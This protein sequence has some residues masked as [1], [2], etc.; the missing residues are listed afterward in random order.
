MKFG[1]LLKNLILPPFFLLVWMLQATQAA[2]GGVTSNLTLWLKADAGVTGTMPISAWADQSG[3]ANDYTSVNPGN[4]LDQTTNTINGNPVIILAPTGSLN[5]PP[6][7]VPNGIVFFILRGENPTT[8]A[9]LSGFQG[10]IALAYEQRVDSG[11]PGVTVFASGGLPSSNDYIADSVQTPFDEVGVLSFERLTGSSF[12]TIQ[13]LVNGARSS[14]AIDTLSTNRFLPLQDFGSGLSAHLA[15]IIV[16]SDALSAAQKQQIETYLAIKYG[17]TL[18]SATDY[19]ASNGTTVLYPSTTSHSGFIHDIAG[20]GQD[21]AS[22]LLQLESKSLSTDSLLTVNNASDLSDGEFLLWG[23]NNG[24]V[25]NTNSGAPAGRLR[26][27]RIWRAAETGDTGTVDLKFE[28]AHLTGIPVEH[29]VLLVDNSD[30]DFADAAQIAASSYASGV[31]MFNGVSLAH[32]DHFTV[33]IL[34]SDG[35]GMADAFDDDDDND[36]IA[37]VDELPGDSD[38]DALPDVR[39]P[40]DDNDTVLTLN[41]DPNGRVPIFP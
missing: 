27:E 23:N 12:Y 24:A 20:I 36:G 11:S 4:S 41:E 39:D 40:D 13:S 14:Q 33:G 34:D 37:D 8:S 7:Q 19:L 1:N 6:L 31:V 3:N 28:L 9:F 29:L 2:P 26:V 38:N 17:L 5:G 15:E 10:Q 21:D 35:D 16:Y 25:A 30:T 32:G 22:A 18:D